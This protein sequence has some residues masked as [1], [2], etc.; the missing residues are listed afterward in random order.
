[1]VDEGCN[2]KSE[3]ED[4]S[5]D[6]VG[7]GEAAGSRHAATI[8]WLP[9]AIGRGTMGDSDLGAAYLG[10]A[11]FEFDRLKRQGEKAIGQVVDDAALEHRLDAE[12]NSIGIL[13]RHLAGNMRS[14]WTNF[15]TSDGE[16]PNRNRES[17]FDLSTAM[18]RAELLAT[19]EE[20]WACVFAAVRPL[21]GGDLGSRVHIRG[22]ELSVLQAI[23]RQV[24]H[25]AGHVGQIV[26]LAK[27]LAGASWQSQS[28]PRGKSMA[29]QWAYKA[30]KAPEQA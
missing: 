10:A 18:S 15:L 2:E 27:H 7:M 13:V 11:L 3:T 28:I 5:R 26:F 30:P 16:K 20:G 12:S 22:E 6:S 24:S 9:E 23:T 19:W 25:Y 1:M 14:R 8:L 17:E 4:Q 29:G 21:A